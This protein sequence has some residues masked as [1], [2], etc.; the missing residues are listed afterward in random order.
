[1]LD[2]IEAL[3]D[4]E[5]HR[6][7][8]T[9]SGRLNKEAARF[10]LRARDQLL[11]LL[12]QENTGR[13][14]AA[15]VSSE[16]AVMRSLLAA[17]PDRVARRREPHSRRGVMVGGRGVRLA[18]A[19]NV[20]E[21]E[22]FVG[23][24]VDAGQTEALVYQASAVERDWLSPLALK[25]TTEA[26]FDANTE[27]VT[28]RRRL[29]YEDLLLEETPGALPDDEQV[30]R[31]LATA[32]AQHLDR[33]LPADD[34][35]AAGFLTRLRCLRQWM[36]ELE[37]PAFADVELKELLSWLC[38]GRRSFADLRKADWLGAL[39][40][41]LTP[42]QRQAVEREAP[43]RLAVPSG[44]HIT[45]KYELGRPPIL[46]ARIQE[47]F[48]MRE[49]PTVAGGRV[50]VLLHLLAP[51]FRPQQVTDDLA[52]FWNNTYQQVRKELRARYPK[53]AWPEDPWS[54]AAQR[55]PGRR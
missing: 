55:R 3:E 7:A 14:A 24:D 38:P 13:A 50:R 20:L 27:R 45:L 10:I 31:I 16:E 26:A 11:R 47:M 37:L 8:A 51:N 21:P 19:S 53:H 52:S 39:Q 28:A 17:F 23:V 35:P 18:P 41:K 4:Y 6:H 9:S 33:V 43:E 2:R 54:A 22:L 46:A 44:S 12:R 29:C 32:A 25:V 1:V 48:G 42:R 30:S 15:T 40:G 49:T 34:S 5:R 36:P